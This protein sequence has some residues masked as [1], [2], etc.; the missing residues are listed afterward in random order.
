VSCAA[1]RHFKNKRGKAVPPGP[2]SFFYPEKEKLLVSFVRTKALLDQGLTRDGFLAC[3]GEYVAALSLDRKQIARRYFNGKLT[4]GRG[5]YRLFLNRWPQLKE[6]RVGTLEDNRAQNA[7]PDV[8]ARWYANLTLCYR[9]LK[10]RNPLQVFNMD[11]THVEPRQLLLE[12]RTTIL[13]GRGLRKPEVIILPIGSG[14]AACTAAVTVFAGGLLAPLFL[15]VEGKAKG[16]A[17]AKITAE[18]KKSSVPLAARLNDSAM[19]VRRT[20]A[21][22]DNCIF[23]VWCAHFAVFAAACYPGESKLLS[24]DEAKVHVSATG[25]LT[26]LRANVHF[27]AEP[28]KLSQ[29][30]QP[31]DNKHA[32]GRFQPSVRGAVRGRASSCVARGAAFTCVDMVECVK[33]AADNAFTPAALVSAFSAVGMWPLDP[34]K[35]PAEELSEGADREVLDVN[36]ELLVSRLTPVVRK[37]L[38]CPRIVQGTLSTV[39]RA[40][41]LTAPEV[42]E[43]LQQL[44]ADKLKNQQDQEVSRRQREATVAAN[45]AKKAERAAAKERTKWAKVWRLVSEEAAEEGRHRVHRLYPSPRK[46]VLRERASKER[47]LF[48]VPNTRDCRQRGL[49]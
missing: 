11:E 49:L 12:A 26:L 46:L 17:V 19:V 29:V 27:V 33:V 47:K 37:D 22:F 20:P 13:G 32:F 8:V 38:S 39:G 9:D 24:L 25:L 36:L 6:H 34:T 31:V 45:K 41:V 28:S 14:A 15:V 10:I 2:L 5:I 23:D 35:I 4:P 1:V 18:C 21:G 43:A 16:H 30:F 40:T 42:L 3:C 48:H 7:L 44:D